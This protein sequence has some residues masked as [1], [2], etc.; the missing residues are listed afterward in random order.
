MFFLSGTIG[1]SVFS[2]LQHPTPPSVRKRPLAWKPGLAR[3]C[4][5]AGVAACLL[6]TVP[7]NVR[8]MGLQAAPRQHCP[9][10][11]DHT[12]FANRNGDT[13][14]SGWG[15]GSRAQCPPEPSQRLFLLPS[16]RSPGGRF[17]T[18]QPPGTICPSQIRRSGGALPGRQLCLP[19][20]LS[21]SFNIF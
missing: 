7:V 11:L 18:Q 12:R 8:A 21:V 2:G 6:I 9:V 4:R 13:E 16:R 1:S 3:R 5:W 15:R 19:Y 20:G 14:P 17:L 10:R